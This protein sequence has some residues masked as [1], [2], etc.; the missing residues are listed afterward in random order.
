MTLNE[1]DLE[2]IFAV[3]DSA[4]ALVGDKDKSVLAEELVRHMIDYGMDLKFFAQEVGEHDQ[5]LDEAV[6]LFLE[7]SEESE[8]EYWLVDVDEWE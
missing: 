3:Y 2:F 6:E 4:R 1:N 7:Q 5:Y 8:E